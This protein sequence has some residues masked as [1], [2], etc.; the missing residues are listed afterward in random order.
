MTH[1]RTEHDYRVTAW[2]T[3]GRTG[4]AMSDSAPKAIHFSVAPDSRGL[5]GAG[6]PWNFCW[7]R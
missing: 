2:W 6:L 3:S 7:R 1:E 5:E 4:I